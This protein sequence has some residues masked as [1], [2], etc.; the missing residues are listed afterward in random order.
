MHNTPTITLHLR[1]NLSGISVQLNSNKSFLFLNEQREKGKKTT[2]TTAC[3]RPFLTPWLPAAIAVVLLNTQW[4]AVRSEESGDGSLPRVQSQHADSCS[5][6][7]DIMNCASSNNSHHHF[8]YKRKKQAKKNFER[9]GYF[10]SRK[11]TGL[12]WRTKLFKRIPKTWKFTTKD[13]SIP[14]PTLLLSVV[15]WGEKKTTLNSKNLWL[16]IGKRLW[17]RESPPTHTLRSIDQKIVTREKKNIPVG[18]EM[19]RS[20]HNKKRD[21]AFYLWVC[22]F[23]LPFFSPLLGEEFGFMSTTL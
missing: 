5:H 17:E 15:C 18:R 9:G 22:V 20:G 3:R 6:T 14:F 7:P 10:E 1:S 23:F 13:E 2:T 19:W 8:Q 16:G 12:Q 21:G 4:P 11:V